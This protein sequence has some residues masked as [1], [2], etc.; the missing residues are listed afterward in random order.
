MDF[1]KQ[2]EFIETLM[3]FV[4]NVKD[5]VKD[6]EYLKAKKTLKSLKL[7]YELKQHSQITAFNILS[8][9]A[10]ILPDDLKAVWI[11]FMKKYKHLKIVQHAFKDVEFFMKSLNKTM[12]Q[13]L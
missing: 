3:K 2:D 12:L 6:T 10:N 7:K 5:K 4:E 13:E 8:M 1:S 9:E 11:T